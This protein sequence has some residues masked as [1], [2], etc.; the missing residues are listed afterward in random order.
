[1]KGVVFIMVDR[2]CTLTEE[3]ILEK[4]PTD[5]CTSCGCYS[6]DEEATYCTWN[7]EKMT[8]NRRV[9]KNGSITWGSL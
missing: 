3:E 6:S 9:Y 8:K 2:N 4:F 5:K 1:M 7:L